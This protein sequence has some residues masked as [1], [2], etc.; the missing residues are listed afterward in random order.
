MLT[1]GRL[2]GDGLRGNQIHHH[3]HP[4]GDGREESV[5]RDRLRGGERDLHPARGFVH[6]DAPDQAK[7]CSSS[8]VVGSPVD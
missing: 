5:P 8:G 4:N 1:S 7:V 2:S 6:G 3:I